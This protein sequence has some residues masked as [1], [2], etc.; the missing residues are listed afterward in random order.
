M[1]DVFVV[2]TLDC[3][4]LIRLSEVVYCQAEKS[5]CKL[6]LASG[7]EVLVSQNMKNVCAQLGKYF[8]KISKSVVVHG[9]YIVKIDKKEKV[10]LLSNGK[11]LNYTA[12]FS[13]L[14][15]S[16]KNMIKTNELF[17]YN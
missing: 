2:N 11:S 10:V 16:I 5:Y 6:F 4:Q 8:I 1:E 17:S 7:D 13:D 12:K 3:L 9:R 14:E 15:S